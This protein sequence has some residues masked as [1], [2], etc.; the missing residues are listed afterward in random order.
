[1]SMAQ[2]ANSSLVISD[3]LVIIL[4]LVQLHC[5]LPPTPSMDGRLYSH[6]TIA[7]DLKTP[8]EVIRIRYTPLHQALPRDVLHLPP[9]IQTWLCLLHKARKEKR[10]NKKTM[11]WPWPF[12]CKKKK[13]IESVRNEPPDNVV[14]MSFPVNSSTENVLVPALPPVRPNNAPQYLPA[15]RTSKAKARHVTR[16]QVQVL[17]LLIYEQVRIQMTNLLPTSK[18]HPTVLSVHQEACRDVLARVIHWA[19]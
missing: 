6:E 16:H 1:M 3:P 17:M 14:K 2:Q 18:Q 12:N 11:T 8:R 10:L 9:A 15:A 19:R 4:L 7:R 13:K 5:Q